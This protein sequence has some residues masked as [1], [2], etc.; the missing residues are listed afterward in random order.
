V[1]RERERQRASSDVSSLDV[2]TSA[3]SHVKTSIKGQRE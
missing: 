2:K 1:K 3:S